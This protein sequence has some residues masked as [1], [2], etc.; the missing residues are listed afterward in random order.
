MA[1]NTTVYKG[2]TLYVGVT[3]S[4]L[5]GIKFSSTLAKHLW[6]SV[7][8]QSRTGFPLERDV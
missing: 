2:S 7:N 3:D 4:G 6:L 8:Y 1:N 5:Y